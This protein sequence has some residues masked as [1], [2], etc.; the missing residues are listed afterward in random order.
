MKN[1][2]PEVSTSSI[3]KTLEARMVRIEHEIEVL[4]KELKQA[5]LGCLRIDKGNAHRQYFRRLAAER[6]GQYIPKSNIALARSLAQKEYNKELIGVLRREHGALRQ[7]VKNFHPELVDEVYRSMS[8]LRKPLVT[9]IRLTDEDYIE[10]WLREAYE[11]LGFDEGSPELFTSKK[12]Q[13][14]SKSEILIAEGL[15][16]F[17][18]P[19]RYEYPLIIDKEGAI[20]PDFYCLDPRTRRVIVW[21]HFGMMSDPAYAERFARKMERYRKAGFYPGY[22]LIVTF[23]TNGHSLNSIEVDEMIKRNFFSGML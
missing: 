23:E 11:T 10:N 4:E 6:K 13:V 16:R 19:F 22:N 1:Y 7:L 8:I 9:P 20:Y 12:L 15:Y 17:K 18:I 5:P 2:C 3:I 21:E 14:R